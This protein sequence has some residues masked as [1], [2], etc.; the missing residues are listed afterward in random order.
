MFA[1][2][3]HPRYN[4]LEAMVKAV[5]DEEISIDEFHEHLEM[6]YECTLAER[7]ELR[8]VYARSDEFKSKHADQIRRTEEAIDLYL[9]GIQT[10]DQYCDE[11]DP[12]CLR[13]GLKT[14]KKGSTLL[15]SSI[16][17]MEDLEERG[18]QIDL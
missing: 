2:N 16:E 4:K 18:I 11:G 9:E 6:V 15:L 5:K 3:Q 17:V 8:T 7:E 1:R 14:F 12:K 10:L 13:Q